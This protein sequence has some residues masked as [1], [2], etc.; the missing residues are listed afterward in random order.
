MRKLFFIILSLFLIFQPL[1]AGQEIITGF[2]EK[3]LPVLNEELRKLK[4]SV[5][6]IAIPTLNSLVG[7]SEQGDILY[8]NGTSWVVL[9]HGT[10]GQYLETNG[11]AANP[12]WSTISTPT[13]TNTSNVVFCFGLGGGSHV[14]NTNGIIVNDSI[15]AANTEIMCGYWA[16]QGTTYKTIITS[17]FKKIAGISTVTVW[18]N[19]WRKEES[20]AEN[21]YQANCQVTIG[22]A[23]GNVSGSILPYATPPVAEWQ[24]FDIDVSGLTNGTTYDVTIQLK[25]VTGNVVVCLGSIIGIA[26]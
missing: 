12:S 4:N 24:T 15:L 21:P 18:C 25:S 6:S 3:D 5:D 20:T 11:N 1:F 26:S 23:S 19:I 13:D 9:H 10:D 22:S 14:A 16:V 7:T 17:K 2:E 8:Y